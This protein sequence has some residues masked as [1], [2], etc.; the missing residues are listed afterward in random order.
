MNSETN[1]STM[2]VDLDSAAFAE[3]LR[4][5]DVV[6][7][8]VRTP[9]EYE[10]GHID[11]AELINIADPAFP[12]RV[13]ELDRDKTYLVYCRSGNRS[14]TAGQFMIQLGFSHVYNLAEGIISW[15]GDVVTGASVER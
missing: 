3:Q 9:E 5:E 12:E 2:P 13:N 6:L 1:D 11:G 7:L 8:D 10:F 4:N 14:W 15:T